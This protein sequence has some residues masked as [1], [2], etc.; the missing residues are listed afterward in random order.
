M[1][2]AN[3]P[4]IDG[5]YGALFFHSGVVLLF[6]SLYLIWYNNIS[7]EA[8]IQMMYGGEVVIKNNWLGIPVPIVVN[9]G[10]L[11]VGFGCVIGLVFTVIQIYFWLTDDSVLKGQSENIKRLAKITLGADVLTAFYALMGGA[12]TYDIFMA[13]PVF[14]VVKFLFSVFLSVSFLSI[15]SEIL[16]SLSIEAIRMNYE[17]GFKIYG[18][19]FRAVAKALDAGFFD[20]VS[21]GAK[22]SG[23]PSMKPVQSSTQPSRREQLQGDPRNFQKPSFGDKP[24]F[25]RPQSNQDR[26][27][28]LRERLLADRE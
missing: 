3:I 17:E 16:F 2:I 12:F 15:G 23:Q 26:A 4:K 11:P 13:D 5:W 1:R 7:T 18:S 25:G 10:S 14:F 9:G 21:K 8:F 28:I 24:D 6:C 20:Q 27:D 22:M 19:I